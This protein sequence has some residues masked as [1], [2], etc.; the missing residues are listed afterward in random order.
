MTAVARE[1]E[2]DPSR[3]VLLVDDDEDI[4]E[5]VGEILRDQGCTVQVAHNGREA[6]D[7]LDAMTAPPQLV[8]LDLMMPELD[9]AQF[10]AILDEHPGYA[11]VPV[12]VVTASRQTAPAS[13][14][15]KVA[16]WL[17]KPVEYDDLVSTV[18]RFVG[19]SA[20]PRKPPRR[21]ARDVGKFLERRRAELDTLRA[22]L[23]SSDHFEIRRIGH[24][25][26]GMGASFGFPDLAELGARLENAARADDQ[27]A[28]HGL[29]DELAAYVAKV[30][31]SAPRASDPPTLP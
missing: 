14:R 27:T 30:P 16:G 21:A 31:A 7:A 11:G 19:A 29:I 9:G 15:G 23:A 6:L 26:K 3:V 5:I 22:A 12:V 17:P 10:L 1:V 18:S 8:L 28:M 25:L 20:P 4:R 2:V 13:V 24:N